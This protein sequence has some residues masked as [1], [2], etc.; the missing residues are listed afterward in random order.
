MKE[1][2]GMSVMYKHT[3]QKKGI[4]LLKFKSSG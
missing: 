3:K 1:L 4:K 2:I